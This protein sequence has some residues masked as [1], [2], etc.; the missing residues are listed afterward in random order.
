[1]RFLISIFL[2]SFF[3][4]NG[5]RCEQTQPGFVKRVWSGFASPVTTQSRYILIGGTIATTMVYMNKRR[6]YYQ[7]RESFKDAQ[8]LGEY[9]VVGRVLGWGFLNG[10]YILGTAI[11]GYTDDDS[12]SL[13]N[14]AMMS[15]A[16]AYT[17]AWIIGLKH[18]IHERRPGFPDQDNSFPSGHTA[19][20]VAFASVVAS[21]HG[22]YWGSLAYATAGFI[23]VSRINDD[24]HYLHDVLAGATIGAAYGWGIH[25][26]HSKKNMPFW[27]TLLPASSGSGLS[28]LAGATF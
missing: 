14:A 23:G 3:V 9:G 15:E 20:S 17:L 4:P 16:S 1:M 12:T 2:L 27:F 19:M 8:P 10:L 22:W 21:Q 24:W 5:S 13:D 11:K 25:Y 6:H 28:L 26:L 18:F 7:K